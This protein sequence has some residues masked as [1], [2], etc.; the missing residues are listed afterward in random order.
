MQWIHEE[1]AQHAP[2]KLSIAEDLRN[3]EW[4]VKDTG[5]GGAGFGS[6]WD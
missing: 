6:Q 2:E 5:A 4:L 1:M 3:N